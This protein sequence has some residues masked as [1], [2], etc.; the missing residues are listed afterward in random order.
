MR[1]TRMVTFLALVLA[2]VS[3]LS[4]QEAAPAPKEKKIR[5]SLMAGATFT[6]LTGTAADTADLSMRVGPYGTFGLTY[7]LSPAF[8]LSVE[9]SLIQKGGKQS[10]VD[11]QPGLGYR[12]LYAEFPLLAKWNLSPEGSFQ[13]V[14]LAG[15][16]FAFEL[17]CKFPFLYVNSVIDSNCYSLDYTRETSE[18]GGVA[19]IE[20]HKGMWFLTARYMMGFT[21]LL[22]GTGAPDLKNSGF[23]A[24]LGITF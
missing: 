3:S 13:P 1:M 9:A 18:I 17:D 8:G 2:G 20:L 12:I 6:N 22:S 11:N 14:L 23:L 4:A 21:N 5:W 7:R 16:T 15:P 10:T 24:G 19:G